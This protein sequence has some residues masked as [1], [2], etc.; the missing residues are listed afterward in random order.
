MSKFTQDM[1]L[2]VSGFTQFRTSKSPVRTHAGRR[3]EAFTPTSG[4]HENP[5]PNLRDR[6]LRSWGV[7]DVRCAAGR[8]SRAAS[9]ACLAFA[10]PPASALVVLVAG[11]SMYPARAI[12]FIDIAAPRCPNLASVGFRWEC[13][14]RVG[15]RVV[16]RAS[17]F[18]PRLLCL[19][20]LAD[21]DGPA[22]WAPPARE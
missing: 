6:S 1:S 3:A 4:P 10:R 8:P 2:F 9:P 7:R 13:G 12:S 22:S 15:T 20:R 21:V 5:S 17:A 16:R 18:P 14:S 11:A 19:P